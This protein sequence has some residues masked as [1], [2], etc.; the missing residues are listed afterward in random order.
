M[1][2]EYD[3]RCLWVNRLQTCVLFREGLCYLVAFMHSLTGY[4]TENT[5]A[6]FMHSLTGYATEGYATEDS[7]AVLC[8]A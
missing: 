8:T 2:C 6:V 7:N 5:N 3:I 1:I 4:A